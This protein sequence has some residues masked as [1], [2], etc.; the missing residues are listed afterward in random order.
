MTFWLEYAWLGIYAITTDLVLRLIEPLILENLLD[1]FKPES[2]VSK[3]YALMYA[4]I[5]VA[6]NI[7]GVLIANQ[8]Y[9][10][11]LH[12]GMRI[13]ASCCTVIYR[14]PESPKEDENDIDLD[15]D[16]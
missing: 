8:Y 16:D 1:Y 10:E 2:Q 9:L 13:R 6:M 3:N 11:V 12:S 15:E 7:L 5:L 4:G 14:K